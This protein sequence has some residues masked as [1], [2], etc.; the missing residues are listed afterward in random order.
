MIRRYQLKKIVRSNLQ[1]SL[2]SF[3]P[4]WRSRINSTTPANCRFSF[5]T[6]D[7]TYVS[8]VPRN[9]QWWPIIDCLLT[10]VY[11]VLVGR[12]ANLIGS[13]PLPDPLLRHGLGGAA[14]VDVIYAIFLLLHPPI[15]FSPLQILTFLTSIFPKKKFSELHRSSTFGLWRRILLL[16]V[17]LQWSV[18]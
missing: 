3:C 1:K 10:Y 4:E 2:S 12:P 17:R 9:S 8:D 13:P 5:T 7:S 11:L 6:F 15:R 14:I 16:I 18:I